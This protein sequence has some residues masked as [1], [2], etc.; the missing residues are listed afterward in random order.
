MDGIVFAGTGSRQPFRSGARRRQSARGERLEAKSRSSCAP[1]APATGASFA[2][3]DY[4]AEGMVPGD[5]LN[6]Q[7]ARV[8]LML[9]L[10]NTRDLNEIRRIFSE[11]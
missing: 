1:A 8:L 4:D 2:R 9:A 7:K 5:N 11:Y 10:T 6:P 3:K